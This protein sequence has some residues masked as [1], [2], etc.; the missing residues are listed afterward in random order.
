M[1]MNF[2]NTVLDERGLM[3]NSTCGLVVGQA[4]LVYS[5][6]KGIHTGAASGRWELGGGS[7]G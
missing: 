3:Q 5:G 6:S 4:K 1:W 7:K 2:K